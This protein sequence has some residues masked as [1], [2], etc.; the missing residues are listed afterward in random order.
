MIETKNNKCDY[1][2]YRPSMESDMY[3]LNVPYYKQKGE[4]ELLFQIPHFSSSCTAPTESL[5]PFN[6]FTREERNKFK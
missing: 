3:K 4:H 1:N 2:N 6:N 5:N